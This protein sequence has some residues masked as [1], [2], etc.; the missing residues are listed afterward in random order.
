MIW[1]AWRQ[2]RPQAIV[3]AC[4][5]A[6]TALVLGLAGLHLEHLYSAAGL[7]RCRAAAGC[8]QASTSFQNQLNSGLG[9]H[10]RH[11]RAR[12]AATVRSRDHARDQPLALGAFAVG[13]KAYLYVDAHSPARL[14]LSPPGWVER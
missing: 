9:N 5:L 7:T 14:S 12:V 6:A 8:D 10:L 1:L 2:F 11:V 13:L 3:A 4:V